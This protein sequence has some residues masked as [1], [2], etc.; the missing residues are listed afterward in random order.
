MDSLHQLS[1]CFFGGVLIWAAA[2]IVRM[3]IIYEDGIW[4]AL[5]HRE[6]EA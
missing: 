2:E 3:L 5:A 6:D 1:V 4:A